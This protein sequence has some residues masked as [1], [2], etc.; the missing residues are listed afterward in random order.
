MID[1]VG[2]RRKYTQTE[3]YQMRCILLGMTPIVPISQDKG[4]IALLVEA[5]LQTCLMNGTTLE[6]LKEADPR[7]NPKYIDH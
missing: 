3:L 7:S 4:I 2:P 1:A 5:R 6:D